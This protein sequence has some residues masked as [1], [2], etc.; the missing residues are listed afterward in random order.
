MDEMAIF[1]MFQ[2]VVGSGFNNNNND[3][4]SPEQ[5]IADMLFFDLNLKIT[6]LRNGMPRSSQTAQ[7]M[8]E[9]GITP[10]DHINLATIAYV[11]GLKGFT[12]TSLPGFPN[13]IKPIDP[14]PLFSGPKVGVDKT[15]LL[16]GGADGGLPW[17]E[18]LLKEMK[19]TGRRTPPPY[20]GS[21]TPTPQYVHDV[22][23]IDLGLCPHGL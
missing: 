21:H 3:G 20:T 1:R 18:A 5:K 6:A 8:R 23:W 2:G 4:A 11:R 14:N 9:E 15:K 10:T 13:G 7:D 19:Q 16:T 17:P 22:K 12:P